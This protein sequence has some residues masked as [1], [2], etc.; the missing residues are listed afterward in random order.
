MNTKTKFIRFVFALVIALS[1]LGIST[2]V[3][4]ADRTTKT[5]YPM[6]MSSVITDICDF[7]VNVD[8]AINMT[9]TDYFGENGA[10]M[11]MKWHFKEQDTFT[12]NGKTLIGLPYTSNVEWLFDSSGNVI[13]INAGGVVE[14]ILLPDGS[15]FISAGRSYFI[16]HPGASFLLTPDKGNLVHTPTR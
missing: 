1:T 6:S 3:A 13:Q 11:R 7:Q 9:E 14:K 16:N 2:S 12:A 15:L 4:L 5:Q 10:L 8:S